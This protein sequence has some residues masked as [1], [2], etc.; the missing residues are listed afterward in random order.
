MKKLLKRIKKK[1]EDQRAD[2][3]KNQVELKSLIDHSQ[4][5]RIDTIMLQSS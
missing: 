2:E 1:S 4:S 3:K 5:Y